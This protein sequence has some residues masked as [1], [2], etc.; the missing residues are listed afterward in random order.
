MIDLLFGDKITVLK[1]PHRGISAARNAVIR[2]S[3]GDLSPAQW[4][5]LIIEFDAWQA[6][7]AHKAAL[8]EKRR[9]K[10]TA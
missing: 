9:K 2:H 5:P 6:D 4:R 1:L 8:F 3:H 10:M 7:V